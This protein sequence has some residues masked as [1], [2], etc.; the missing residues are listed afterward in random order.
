[1]R[2]DI[3]LDEILE[4]ASFLLKASMYK[5]APGIVHAYYPGSG[6]SPMNCGISST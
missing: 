4:V 2:T 1:M 3:E 6:S 5:V